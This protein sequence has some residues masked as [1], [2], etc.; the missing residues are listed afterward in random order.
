M[1]RTMRP[2]SDARVASARATR[3]VARI[4]LL[5]AITAALSRS[6][7]SDEVAR[8]LIERAL[9]T[10]GAR[11]G[12]LWVIEAGGS[13]AQLLHAA[14]APVG[15]WRPP[16][17]LPLGDPAAGPE[18]ATALDGAPRFI[19]SRRELRRAYP[20][21]APPGRSPELAL[22][23]LPL[24]AEGR[25]FGVASL[26]FDGTRRFDEEE[27]VFL[28]V[29]A[30]LAAQALARA[31]LYESEQAARAEAEAAERRAAFL[32]EAGA[33]LVASLDWEQTMA[34][35]ARLAVT[36]VADGC[37]VEV[38]ESL[39]PGGVPV[40]MAHTDPATVARALEWRRSH[41]PDPGAA[42]G[43]A[44]VIRSGCSE[45]YPTVTD[46]L[47]AAALPDPAERRAARE[48]RISSAM[49]VALKARGRTLGAI[50]LVSTRPGRYGQADLAMAEELGR[51]AG[52]ALDNAR[53][54]AQAQRA[55]EIRDEVL[56][57]VSHDLKNPLEAI[58]LSSAM[59]LRD[60]ES[61]RARRYAE[62]IQR[63][64]GRMDR[65]IRAL[66]DLS[67]LE[68][69]QLRVE[70]RPERLESVVEEALALLAPLAVERGVA[71]A[72]EGGPLAEPVPCD[73]ERIL[74][75]LSNL[76]GN[77][78][79]F[80]PRGGHVKVVTELAP[81]EA[82]VRVEDDGPGIAPEVLP[83]VFDRFWKGDASRRGSG[84]GLSIA[85]G[86]VEAHG[87]RLEARSAPGAGSTFTFTLP[88]R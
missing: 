71:L 80:T 7:T 60:A 72:A 34:S 59:L 38:P 33:L 61:P 75:V 81:G 73:R 44:A 19:G 76:V 41:P 63:S 36:G 20:R 6:V 53:L 57:V 48:L 83:H 1:T 37:A 13:A 79:Q 14:G 52:L 35:V 30:R 49:V 25:C 22:A 5:Q 18:I 65:L 12:S 51:R 42:M 84:L 87:G 28:G 45:L 40:V 66:L 3:P 50:T 24:E 8:V 10:V 23:C 46:E 32:A 55:V 47:L 4:A 64:A 85:R 86:L 56:A 27:R 69:G 78:L 21:M 43:P 68:A 74:Q 9:E 54:Y 11:Q 2:V 88:R 26:A 62:T 58:Y 70:V 29:L 16:A 15:A 31:R 39:A 17:R 82:R 67:A 77:A